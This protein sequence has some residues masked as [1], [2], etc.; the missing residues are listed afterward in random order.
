[1]GVHVLE[2][3]AASV[4]GHLSKFV[5]GANKLTLFKGTEDCPVVNSCSRM[6]VKEIV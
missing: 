1:M 6:Q 4:F 3:V 5:S 2:R